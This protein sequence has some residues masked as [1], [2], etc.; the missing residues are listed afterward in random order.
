LTIEFLFPELPALYGDAMNVEYLRRA[1][2]D[3]RV[4]KTRH[5]TRP[6]F[7]DGGVDFVYI[8]A[9]TE[10]GQELALDALSPY[11]AEILRYI[12]SGGAML[13]TG[14]ALELFGDRIVDGERTIT[15]LGLFATYAVRHM[16]D[17]YNGLYLGKL[18]DIEIV[19]F[20]SQFSHSYGDGGDGLFQTVRGVGLNPGVAAEGLRR[21]NFM[22]TYLL[23]PLLILNPPF[24]AHLLELL[25]CGG[26]ELPFEAAALD[27]YSARLL[28]FSDPGT[29][30]GYK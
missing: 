14:N 21:R 22:A 28:E 1:A 17:R 25:G 3:S 4:I 10:A 5:S 9:M 23:G 7:I 18:G 2:P 20:K 12:D 11:R 8:G 24:T 6:A 26:I 30:F 19:G 27:S 13:A 15:A 16:L 29:G